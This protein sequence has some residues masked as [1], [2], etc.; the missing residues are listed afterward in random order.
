MVDP[1]PFTPNHQFCQTGN[2]VKA[3]RWK[4]VDEKIWTCLTKII[5]AGNQSYMG[6]I[7]LDDKPCQTPNLTEV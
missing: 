1:L 2:F 4:A 7:T 3:Y 6:L 5:S